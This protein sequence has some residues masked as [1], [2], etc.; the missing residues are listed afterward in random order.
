MLKNGGYDNVPLDVVTA[1]KK[2]VNV[3]NY[4]N[5]ERLRPYYHSFEMKP[6]FLMAAEV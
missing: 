5:T 3:Q 1:S 6:F 4:Y 2:L